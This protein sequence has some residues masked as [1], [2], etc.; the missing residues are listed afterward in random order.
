ML[1]VGDSKELPACSCEIVYMWAQVN[2]HLIVF[3]PHHSL[4]QHH[5]KVS[6]GSQTDALPYNEPPSQ[7]CCHHPHCWGNLQRIHGL[8]DPRPRYTV[9]PHGHT[10]LLWH[11]ISVS[12]TGANLTLLFFRAIGRKAW[13]GSQCLPSSSFVPGA[14]HK[15]SLF[16]CAGFWTEHSSEPSQGLVISPGHVLHEWLGRLWKEDVKTVVI[17]QECKTLM[18]GCQRTMPFKFNPFQPARNPDPVHPLLPLSPTP[19]VLSLM[20]ESCNTSG[21]AYSIYRHKKL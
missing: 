7:I 15:T 17:N 5:H 11:R 19:N 6:L 10:E 16:I 21:I 18:G 3:S 12:G 4:P 9:L 20:L 8:P 14:L 1:E 13:G 2:S